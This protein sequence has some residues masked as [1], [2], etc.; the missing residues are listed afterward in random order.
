MHMYVSVHDI[1]PLICILYKL[2]IRMTILLGFL[3]LSFI[4]LM[5]G[6][7]EEPTVLITFKL[8]SKDLSPTRS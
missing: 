7:S 2:I 1:Y 5:A 6:S 3:R 4:R 8:R